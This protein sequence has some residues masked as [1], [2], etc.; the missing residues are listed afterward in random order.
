MLLCYNIKGSEGSGDVILED[1]RM[2]NPY[3]I[4]SVFLMVVKDKE[5]R[6]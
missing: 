5:G 1:K 6:K 3:S 2:S 4:I